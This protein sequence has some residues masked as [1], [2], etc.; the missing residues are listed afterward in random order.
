MAL[1]RMAAQRLR[2]AKSGGPSRVGRLAKFCI[3]L[4]LLAAIVYTAYHFLLAP[5][6]HIIASRNPL[7]PSPK[8]QPLVRLPLN[9]AVPALPAAHSRPCDR[10]A[11]STTALDDSARLP[12]E[13]NN[14]AN[15]QSKAQ[16]KALKK[17]PALEN[18][19]VKAADIREEDSG[20]RVWAAAE[21]GTNQDESSEEGYV[22]PAVLVD[23]RELVQKRIH[24]PD[25]VQWGM[26]QM[27]WHHPSSPLA[28]SGQLSPHADYLEHDATISIPEDHFLSLSFS[29]ALQP[30]KVIPYYYRASAPDLPGFVKEDVT[31]TTLVTSNR[32]KV[33]EKLVERYQGLIN[34]PLFS[35]TLLIRFE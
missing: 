33:F 23:G 34:F 17:H 27:S 4:Y 24:G 11:T 32:F 10:T 13:N 31:I 22:R 9:H 18:A 19:A 16:A 15:A 7:A 8:P 5:T 35:F 14:L 2:S 26:D 20:D 28:H 6:Y 3:T 25:G 12:D 21:V 30:S 1:D 29:S